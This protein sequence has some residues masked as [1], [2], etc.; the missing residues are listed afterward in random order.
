ME[1]PESRTHTAPQR[2]RAEEAGFTLVE[3]LVVMLILGVVA[4][5]VVFGVGGLNKASAA[6]ACRADYKTVETAQTAYESQNGRPAPTVDRLLGV[7]LKDRPGNT[8]DYRI[9]IDQHGDVTVQSVNPAHPA[10]AGNANC[11]YA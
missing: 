8:S 4:G 5:I 9:A 3:L 7:W 1:G 10:Q 6:A 11:V 2:A